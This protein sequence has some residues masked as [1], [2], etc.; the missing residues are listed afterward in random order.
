MSVQAALECTS[1]YAPKNRISDCLGGY[2]PD[3]LHYVSKLGS[4]LESSYPY[5]AAQY[6]IRAGFPQTAGVCSEKNRIYLGETKVNFYAPL[7]ASGGLTVD[8]IKVILLTNGPQMIGVYAN[9]EF[10]SYHTGTFTGCPE[11]AYGFINHAIVLIGWTK[12]GWIAKNQ[13]GT[14]WG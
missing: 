2:F 12:T 3:P 9:N 7:I 14:L 1:Y 13:W 10:L 5:L 6:G 8:Q 4:V 11:N